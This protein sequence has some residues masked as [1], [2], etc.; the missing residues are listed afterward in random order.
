MVPT[1]LRNDANKVEML[2]LPVF[3]PFCT[4]SLYAYASFL[5]CVSLGQGRSCVL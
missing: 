2:Y 1:L 5:T 3:F 4:A